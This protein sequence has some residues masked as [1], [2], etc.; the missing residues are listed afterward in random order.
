MFVLKCIVSLKVCYPQ[1]CHASVWNI[2]C[3]KCF[4]WIDSIAGKTWDDQ[5]WKMKAVRKVSLKRRPVTLFPYGFY[6][7]PHRDELAELKLWMRAPVSLR[8]VPGSV[9]APYSI[10]LFIRML[11]REELCNLGATT[12]KGRETWQCFLYKLERQ[13]MRRTCRLRVRYFCRILP[14]IFDL[15]LAALCLSVLSLKE[16]ACVAPIALYSTSQ[17]LSLAFYS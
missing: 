4:T 13:H 10:I 11:M 14:W 7:K 6:E 15:S 3:L 12:W 5:K 9:L 2:P 8:E 17:M 16:T 1:W